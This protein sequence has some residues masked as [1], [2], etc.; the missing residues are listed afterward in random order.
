MIQIPFNISPPKTTIT[1]V[2]RKGETGHSKQQEKEACVKEE[3]QA[4]GA[5]PKIKLQAVTMRVQDKK[6]NLNPKKQQKKI[7]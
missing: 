7:I 3:K 1:K 2:K 6:R 5:G 4:I